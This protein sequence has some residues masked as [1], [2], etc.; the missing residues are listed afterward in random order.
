[1]SHAPGESCPL[2]A[3]H[4]L[5]LVVVQAL[6]DLTLSD[7]AHAVMWHLR[8]RLDLVEYRPQYVASLAAATR[9]KDRAVTRALD[10]LCAAGYLDVQDPQARPRALRFP[11]SRRAPQSRAA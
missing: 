2:I 1:M 6:D 3:A 9:R 4:G 5:P 10:A 11:W 7:T 8:L